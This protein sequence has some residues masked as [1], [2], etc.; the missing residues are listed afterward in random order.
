MLKSDFRGLSF[1]PGTYRASVWDQVNNHL[2]KPIGWILLVG[3]AVLWMTYG[4]YVFATSAV[5]PWEKMATGAIA[6]GILALLGSVIWDRLREWESDP[7]KDVQ[8]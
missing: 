4:A 5:S 2:T 1:H 3:G 8:R 7:Y 6:I